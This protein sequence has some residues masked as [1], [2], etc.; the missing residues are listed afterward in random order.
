[1]APLANTRRIAGRGALYLGL[2]HGDVFGEIGALSPSLQ[3]DERALLKQIQANPSKIK[4]E[5]I[6]IDGV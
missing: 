1:M 6:W 3:W 2:T 5:R 4:D